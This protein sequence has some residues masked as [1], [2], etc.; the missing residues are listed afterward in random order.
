MLFGV[1][2]ELFKTNLVH[3]NLTINTTKEEKVL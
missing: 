1:K 3:D 2:D